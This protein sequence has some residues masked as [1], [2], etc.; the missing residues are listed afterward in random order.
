MPSD[1]DGSTN[2]SV[3][4][5]YQGPCSVSIAGV[6][7]TNATQYTIQ[8]LEEYS[9]YAVTITAVRGGQVTI[10]NSTAV[11]MAAGISI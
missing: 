3:S 1:G 4:Y 8:G 11:T 7:Y 2:Y 10:R 6:G 9:S 5:V